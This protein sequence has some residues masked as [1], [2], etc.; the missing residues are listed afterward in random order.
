[1]IDRDPSE[2]VPKLGIAP[3][4][5]VALAPEIFL[6][7]HP[8]RLAGC[9]VVSARAPVPNAALTIVYALSKED[10]PA[11]AAYAMQLADVSSLW[12]AVPRKNAEVEG[13]P[14]PERRAELADLQ[15]IFIPLGLT[16]NKLLSF[17]TMLVAYRFVRKRGSLRAVGGP[18]A[19]LDLLEEKLAKKRRKPEDRAASEPAPAP[20]L[21][22]AVG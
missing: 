8:L 20:R 19:D 18:D 5:K 21:G 16:D 6:L 12:V 3:G 7:A 15:A 22:R 13:L 4:C 1:M 2:L 10:V 9:R 17:G 11:L 14:P